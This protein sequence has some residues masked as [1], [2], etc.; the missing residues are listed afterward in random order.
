MSFKKAAIKA[1]HSYLPPNK[2]T[3]EQLAQ[4][5]P[6]W[7]IK[8]TF[9]N[10]GVA[11]RSIAGAGECTSDLGVIAAE[12]LFASGACAPEN[13]DF[14]LFCTQFPDHFLP[15]SACIRARRVE[16]SCST[17]HGVPAS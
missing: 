8:K 4:K 3:N 1:I 15:A 10:T 7:D 5:F 17:V 14:L 16:I 9:E 2:L 6:D 11:E 12:K 13:I